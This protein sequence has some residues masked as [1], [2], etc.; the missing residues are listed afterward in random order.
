MKTSHLFYIRFS[1]IGNYS[2]RRKLTPLLLAGLIFC[3]PALPAHGQ[4]GGGR[5]TAGEPYEIGTAEQL[6][7]MGGDPNNWDK[8]FI[9]I[10]DI[11]LS[12]YSFSTA[13]I[14]PDLDNTN[15][16]FEG[17]AFNGVFDGANHQVINMKIEGGA[18]DFLG[19]FGM[20]GDEQAEVKNLD[21]ETFSITGKKKSVYHGGLCGRNN[22]TIS[23]CYANGSVRGG[24]VLGGL[25]GQNR[26][27][28]ITQ[29]RAAGSVSGR[30]RGGAVGGLCGQNHKGMILRCSA[31]SSVSIGEYTGGLGG[32][33]GTNSGTISQCHASGSVS[34][35]D[36]SVS[37]GGLCGGNYQ[38]SA[39]ISQCYAT[40][41]IS[42]GFVSSNLGGLCGFNQ[43]GT[44]SRN[45]A[46]G[47][48]SGGSYSS[49]LGG[50]CGFI[51]FGTI[52]RNYATGAV[53]GGLNSWY[54]GGLGGNNDRGMI[55]QCY[56]TGS[57]EETG[58]IYSRHLGGLVGLNNSG[59]ISNCYAT[60]SVTVDIDSDYLGGLCGGN[61]GGAISQCYAIGSVSGGDKAGGLCG[62]N[63]W[64]GTIF[65]SFWDIETGGPDNGL[66]A[67]LTTALM[68]T[69]TT[70]IDAGWDFATPI[71]FIRQE[72][73][74]RLWWEGVEAALKLTPRTLNCRSQGKW[75]KA[76]LTMPEGFTFED[77]DPNTPATLQPL[78]LTSDQ[79]TVSVNQDGLV[80]VNA[81]FD[82]EAFCGAVGNLSE[83]V[84]VFGYLADGSVFYGTASVRIITPG[85][86]ELA[87]L[88]AY[89]LQ[90]GCK[91]PHW[92]G[93]LDLNR[94]SVVN[95]LDF[96]LLQK[97]R[98]E[99]IYK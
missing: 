57:V 51:Q 53:S 32:L 18:N 76:H 87:D 5:G 98:I 97:S 16:T 66:G 69:A 12:G 84:T 19:L 83:G 56:A 89:W 41:A 24:G 3:L 42:G 45:Y 38:E 20:I 46:T 96:A 22:G 36:F 93:G 2:H 99:F 67:G 54:L 30:D 9:L 31:D 90:T 78:S 88:S 63:I 21:L 86:Q 73:Y 33:C 10:A 71:W 77:M 58:G 74:P 23:G 52:S 64:G 60:G 91:K 34:G 85:L 48:V 59:T 37:I 27:G 92:C 13:V 7:F 82:R 25:C 75:V 62:E 4:Y 80:E 15:N 68:Q 43:Y 61:W 55:S 44:I 29:C 79:L 26:Y 94:D 28:T 6:L 50:L 40:G 65:Q 1:G 14:A 35:G 8:H 49:N 47:S 95:M 11:D 70:F 81:S 39:T 17:A 72:E